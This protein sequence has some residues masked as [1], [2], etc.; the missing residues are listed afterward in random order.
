M[1]E[2]LTE[3]DLAANTVICDTLHSAFPN[4]AILSEENTDDLVRLNTSR[5]WIIDPLDGTREFTLGIPEFAV[6]IG[7][8][9]NE[10]VVLGVIYNPIT[11][12]L[13][14]GVVGEGTQ[15]QW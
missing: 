11:E 1:T 12:E 10:E 9:I 5:V 14:T 4:D 2:A 7:L 6:S 15:L 13:I 3:A 8:T